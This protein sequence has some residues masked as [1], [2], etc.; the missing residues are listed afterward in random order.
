[1]NTNSLFQPLVSKG[2]KFEN[3]IVMAPMTRSRSD[4]AENTATELTAKYY[5]QR[6]TAG[7]IV[8]EGTFV[9]KEAVGYINVPAIYSEAQVEGWKKVTKAVHEEG[10]V[11][12]AQ[13]WHVGAMSHPDFHEGRKPLAPSDHNPE[14][15]VFTPEGFK[16]TVAPQPMTLEDIKK[17]IQDFKKGANNAFEAGFDGVEIHAANGYLLQQFFSKN[18]NSRTDDYGGSIENR[19]RILFDIL[20]E[21]KTVVDL[22]KVGVRLNPSLHQLMGIDVDKETIGLYNYIATRLNDYDL[23][24]LHLIEPFTDVSGNENAIQEVAKHFRPLFKGIIIINRGFTKETASQV[25]EEGDADLVSFGV[26]FIANP[27]LVA[28][29]KEDTPLNTTDQ[30][31]FYTPG[32]KGYT[33]Y[34]ALKKENAL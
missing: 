28:R 23:A 29:F 20:D 31:T 17:T 10:G 30:N 5:Q 1:M 13:L 15:Q 3:R 32:E 21:L 24:Y 19:A 34:P 6:A 26:P 22:N 9:N 14:A 33:D 12:F 8:S 27:D 18:S 4:N 11:I 2:L 7:L 25:L 16:T